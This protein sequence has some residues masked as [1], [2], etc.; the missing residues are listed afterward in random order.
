MHMPY[1]TYPFIKCW[2]LH[3]FY[4]SVRVSNAAMNICFYVDE[5]FHFPWVYTIEWNLW[6]TWLY[7]IIGGSAELFPK[8]AHFTFAPEAHQFFHLLNETRYC[9]LFSFLSDSV[10]CVG[11][12]LCCAWNYLLL[13]V[14]V[15]AIFGI[16]CL[17]ECLFISFP[18]FKLQII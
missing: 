9:L 18:Y 7:L 1:I 12:Q 13:I 3:C 2:T 8:T 5:C 6:D 11:L 14:N 16:S 10:V 4:L 15:V 17:E